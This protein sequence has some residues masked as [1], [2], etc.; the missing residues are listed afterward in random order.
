M[1]K[2]A[3]KPTGTSSA[4]WRFNPTSETR[5][6]TGNMIGTPIV[7]ATEVFLER[8]GPAAGASVVAALPQ[9]REHLRP[10]TPALGL[11]GARKYPYPF[12][13]DLVR[14]MMHVTHVADEDAFL[15]E[16]AAAGID[17]SM[18]TTMRTML[19][20][21]RPEHLA[22]RGQESWRAFHDTGT[23]RVTIDGNDYMTRVTDWQRHEVIVCKIAMEVRRRIFE[24]M[25]LKLTMVRRERCVGWGHE[26]CVIRIRWT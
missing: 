17:R 22:A 14:T 7:G 23:V 1:E 4:G 24:R 25:G 2:G 19:R 6:V 26:D 3:S 5:L 9:W 11:I 21:T 20:F 18:T 10:N 16:Y 12:I 8:N 15:R 13:A